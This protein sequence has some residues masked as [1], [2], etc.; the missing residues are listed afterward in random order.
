MCVCCHVQE[1]RKQ[2]VVDQAIAVT[3]DA[4]DN[5]YTGRYNAGPQVI[6]G[7][8]VSQNLKT[9]NISSTVSEVVLSNWRCMGP[10][11]PYGIWN[12]RVVCGEMVD[13]SVH[14][15]PVKLHQPLLLVCNAWLSAILI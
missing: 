11:A 3:S 6:T 13:A 7:H 1:G 9:L 4:V 15:P 14:A 2:P 12:P 10:R 8:S 5:R